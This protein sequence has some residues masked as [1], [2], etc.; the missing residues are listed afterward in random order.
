M[1]HTK[2]R[3]IGQPVTVKKNFE[4]FYHIWAWRPSW[5]CDQDHINNFFLYLK[6]YRQNLVKNGP[7]D[8]EKSMF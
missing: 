4:G 3:G 7:E 2:F 6:A 1:L 8:S 5:S